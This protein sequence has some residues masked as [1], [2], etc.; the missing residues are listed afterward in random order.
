[1]TIATFH[2]SVPIFLFGFLGLFL[3]AA[4]VFWA[5]WTLSGTRRYLI[6]AAVLTAVLAIGLVAGEQTATWLLLPAAVAAAAFLARRHLG[7]WG[8]R[9]T[10]AMIVVAGL[11]LYAI[12]AFGLLIAVAA[13][14]CAPDAYECPL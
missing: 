6:A 14:G 10:A 5:R 9:A 3:C 7:V 12:T 1:M 2:D 8:R 11:P 13:I 4:P